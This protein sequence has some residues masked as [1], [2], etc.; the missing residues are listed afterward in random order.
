REMKDPQGGFFSS[1]DAD[2][3]G[4]EGSYYCFTPDEMISIAGET[5]GAALNALFGITEQGNFADYHGKIANVTVLS[6]R[7]TPEQ[8]MEAIGQSSEEA[9]Q[10][11]ERYSQQIRHYRAK[12][13]APTLDRKVITS[14]NALTMSAVS[15]AY[16]QSGD[17]RYREAAEG[18]V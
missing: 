3:D 11:F 6:R 17:Q 15:A 5:D 13:T 18:I 16:A 14:L 8:V 7:A 2:S 1:F 10:L 9:D 12:P 4:V